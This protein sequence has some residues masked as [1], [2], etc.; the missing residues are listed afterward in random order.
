MESLFSR[1]TVQFIAAYENLNFRIAAEKCLV[2]QPAISKSIKKIES[3]YKMKLFDKKGTKM[4]PTE[5]A[6]DLYKELVSM[7]DSAS[8]LRLKFENLHEGNS[9]HLNIAVGVALQSSQGF[10]DLISNINSNFPNV[11]LNIS[12]MIKD[13]CLPLL[14]DGEIDLWIGDIGDLTNDDQLIK[15]FI[16]KIPL[17]LY[18]NKNNQVFNKKKLSLPELKNQKWSLVLGGTFIKKNKS[19][20]Y[21]SIVYE[22]QKNG[23]NITKNLTTFSSPTALFASA[24]NNGNFAIA[25]KSLSNIAKNFDLKEVD[26]IN[27]LD[28]DVGIIVRNKISNYKIIKKMINFALK[29]LG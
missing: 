19:D 13:T 3:D 29:N 26:N 1:T 17:V 11:S 22:F 2:T 7:R 14:K 9:G 20:T 12:S 15:K 23:I 16:K 27:I 24:K 8:S 10:V 18:A 25:A 28:L 4:T 6:D 5:F 21:N